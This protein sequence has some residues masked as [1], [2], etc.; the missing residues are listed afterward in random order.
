M[1]N[2]AK[3]TFHRSQISD[4]NQR[5]LFKV[6]NSMC[7]AKVSN[8]L[9][10]C[11]S[12]Q[13]LADD[14]VKFFDDKVKSLRKNLDSASSSETISAPSSLLCQVEFDGFCAL[15]EDEIWA[16]ISKMTSKSCSLDP[17]PTSILKL[18]LDELLPIITR[19]VHY[20]LVSFQI[21][22]RSHMSFP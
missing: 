5:N 9:P 20:S 21:V 19:I 16:L 10:S 15:T 2:R 11:D 6:V 4:C 3:T 17:M 8:E 18:C 22:S 7:V 13:I 1:L 14:F 12:P